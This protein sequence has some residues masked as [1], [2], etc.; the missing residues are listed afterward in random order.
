MNG[1]RGIVG[2]MGVAGALVLGGCIANGSSSV[3]S[4]GQY[5]SGETLALIEPGT[6][7]E[8]ELIELLGRP[9]RT[10]H[11]HDGR[12]VYVY[13]YKL[14]SKA[15]GGVFIFVAGSSRRNIERTTYF[16]VAGGVVTR[17]WTDGPDEDVR[18]WAKDCDVD[19]DEAD[20]EEI[21]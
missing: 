5:V 10:M 18:D 9:T 17:F 16:E 2:A 6:S 7:S 1:L 4:S 19:L 13:Q 11:H 15:S 21:G 3:K 20:W 8:K 14:D 12:T